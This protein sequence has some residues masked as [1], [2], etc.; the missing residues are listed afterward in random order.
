MG[1]AVVE[2]LHAQ[3]KAKPAV[4]AVTEIEVKNMDAYMKEYAPKAQALIKKSGGRLV[5]ASSSPKS[6]EGKA[7]A[8]RVAVQL[9]KDMDQYMAYRNSAE[10]K[11][12]RAIGNKHA[13]FR[14]FALEARE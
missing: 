3:A 8:P 13:S 1:G 9:W 4:Y 2:G 14:T 5:A 7:P 12:V 10:L 11:E 6:I